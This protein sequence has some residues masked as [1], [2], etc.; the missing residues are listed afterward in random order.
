MASGPPAVR[1]ASH[2]GRL[3]EGMDPGPGHRPHDEDLE[4]AVGHHGHRDLGDVPVEGAE[5]AGQD[6]LQLGDGLAHGPHL[7][8]QGDHDGPVVPDDQ[9]PVQ[10]RLLPDRELQDVAHA[11]TVGLAGALGL[12][13]GARGHADEQGEDREEEEGFGS[14]HVGTGGKGIRAPARGPTQSIAP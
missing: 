13:S 12:R 9:F 3:L 2:R 14:R 5:A 11:E 6:L 7:A 10:F 4:T 8:H 1:M